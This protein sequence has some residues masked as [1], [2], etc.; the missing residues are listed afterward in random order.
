MSVGRYDSITM[1]PLIVNLVSLRS[2]R[3]DAG[4]TS[5]LAF[6]LAILRLG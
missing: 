4:L 1:A 6:S 3:V 2:V 5:V